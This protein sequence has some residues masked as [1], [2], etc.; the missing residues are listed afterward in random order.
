MVDI[1]LRKTPVF[2]YKIRLRLYITKSKLSEL[3]NIFSSKQNTFKSH[4]LYIN[5]AVFC[6]SIL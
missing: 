2:F 5:V 6:S 3:Q 1:S 4:H